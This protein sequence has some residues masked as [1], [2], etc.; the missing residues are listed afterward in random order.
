M[1]TPRHP[2]PPRPGGWSSRGHG[3]LPESARRG[4]RRPGFPSVRQ[5]SWRSG[6]PPI[7]KV[8]GPRHLASEVGEVEIDAL[9]REKSVA[10]REEDDDAVA[11]LLPARLDAK[12]WPIH[13]A[14][15]LR[16]LDDAVVRVDTIQ[17]GQFDVRDNAPETAVELADL[18][19][20]TPTL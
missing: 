14:D 11:E 13:P 3:P 7:E 10:D 16:L 1:P 6:W 5:P 19:L 12:E 18:V 20:A 15:D 9:A 4:A 8:P 17:E 2:P